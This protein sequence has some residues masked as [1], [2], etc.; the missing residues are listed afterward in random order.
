[1][2]VEV[3]VV[4]VEGEVMWVEDEVVWVE[5]EGDQAFRSGRRKVNS[6]PS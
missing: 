5:V 2:W 4:W 3:K 1:M 6:K